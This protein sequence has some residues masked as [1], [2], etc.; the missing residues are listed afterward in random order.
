MS[1]QINCTANA[2]KKIYSLMKGRNDFD[3]KL[4]VYVAAGGCAGLQYAFKLDKTNRDDDVTFNFKEDEYEVNLV[5]D[6]MSLEHLKGSTLEYLED[7]T[8]SRFI[9]QNLNATLTCSCGT[10]FS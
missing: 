3:F 1:E 10:S 9:L 5:I 2:V 8:G 4:R 6:K 7:L